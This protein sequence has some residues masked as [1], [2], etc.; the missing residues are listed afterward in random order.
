MAWAPLQAI[1]ASKRPFE[2]LTIKKKNN[3]MT[4]KQFLKLKPSGLIR[5]ALKDLRA[6]EKDSRYKVNMEHWHWVHPLPQKPE[7]EL[8]HVCFAGSVLAKSFKCSSD[9]TKLLG[10]F[11]VG[12]QDRMT[13]LNAFRLGQVYGG[14][15]QLRR[16]VKVPKRY[17][18]NRSVVS[19][20]HDPKKFKR[21]MATMARFLERKRL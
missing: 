14:L 13:A 9:E 19:Y 21:Q 2:K 6:V 12:V 7:E 1:H 11:P 4:R 15:E 5:L 18:P 8:C 17:I 10:A 20:N 16:A 3:A